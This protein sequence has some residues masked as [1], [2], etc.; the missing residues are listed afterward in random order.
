LS[1]FQK[2]KKIAEEIYH[3]WEDGAI[4]PENMSDVEKRMVGDI[5]LKQVREK[6][7]GLWPPNHAGVLATTGCLEYK[8]LQMGS[9]ERVGKFMLKEE[10]FRRLM[11]AMGTD[12]K[13]IVV[14][15]ND[16]N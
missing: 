3:K 16:F 11:D 14:T 13:S 5:L 12:D 7:W 10:A 9:D 2:R 6:I 4:Q 8:N 15:R 1:E